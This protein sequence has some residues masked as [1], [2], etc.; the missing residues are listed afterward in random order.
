[1]YAR[2]PSSIC[3]STKKKKK[4]VIGMG[5][6]AW[7]LVSGLNNL[8]IDMIP[9]I[10][11]LGIGGLAVALA[12]R[13]TVENVIGSLM[14][15]WDGPYRVGQRI[16]VLEHDGVVESIG[17]RSFSQRDP[18]IEFKR[19]GARLF[20][21]MQQSI[22]D[23]VTDLI[24]KAKLTPQVVPQRRPEIRRDTPGRGAGCQTPL[25]EHDDL[26]AVGA[27]QSR[28]HSG[29]LAGP[30]RRPDQNHAG[31]FDSGADVR[32]RRVDRQRR[33]TQ[34]AASGSDRVRL[35]STASARIDF[36]T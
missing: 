19:E 20:E 34:R 21:E 29:R 13:S 33:R 31:P 3:H 4:K 32:Q 17:L 15:F 14:I 25:F 22:R 10:A 1:M 7:I 26:T 27:E 8:G 9:L 18:R 11:G 2:T 6:F 28:R 24:F 23:K 5:L 16:K 35:P 12:A 36:E 30:G